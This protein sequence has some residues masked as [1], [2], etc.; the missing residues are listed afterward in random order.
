MKEVE[1][2]CGDTNDTKHSNVGKHV[3]RKKARNLY[4]TVKTQ[5][6]Q[7]PFL[8]YS[9]VQRA[10]LLVHMSERSRNCRLGGLYVDK[11]YTQI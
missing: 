4:V 2:L 5:Q 11:A 7:A 6:F 1:S 3:T 8:N 9:H 10:F